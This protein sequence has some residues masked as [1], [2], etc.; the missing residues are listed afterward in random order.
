MCRFWFFTLKI[1]PDGAET[2]LLP[3]IETTVA[4]EGFNGQ[5][6]AGIRL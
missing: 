1:R 4:R 5:V 3:G 2:L 6:T